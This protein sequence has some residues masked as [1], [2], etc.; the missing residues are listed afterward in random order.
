MET[1]YLCCM[2]IRVLYGVEEQPRD[3]MLQGGIAAAVAISSCLKRN[4]GLVFVL[5]C[6]NKIVR[7]LQIGQHDMTCCLK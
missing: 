4:Q 6:G 5:N 2:V 1:N 3:W 7:I